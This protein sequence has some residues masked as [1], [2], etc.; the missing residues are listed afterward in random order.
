MVQHDSAALAAQ[1]C[2]CGECVCEFEREQASMGVSV[3]V[4]ACMPSSVMCLC[5]LSNL[6][7]NANLNSPKVQN[8]LSSSSSS[9]VFVCLRV[10][11]CVCVCEREREVKY[12]S[13]TQDTQEQSEEWSL[14]G[15]EETGERSNNQRLRGRVEAWRSDRKISDT[16][17]KS[18]W[19]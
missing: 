11:V 1:I 5:T 16:W 2:C 14:S 9:T 18:D 7:W 3:C 10:C 15:E 8:I 6:F 19:K 13:Y 4:S 17:R 12:Q